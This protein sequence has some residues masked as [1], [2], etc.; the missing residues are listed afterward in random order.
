MSPEVALLLEA[1]DIVKGQ[2]AKKEQLQIAESLVRSFEDHIGIDDVE[3]HLNEFD[4]VMKA[5]LVS[6]FGLGDDDQDWDE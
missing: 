3:D 6:H 4:R 5:A 1:W 2:I